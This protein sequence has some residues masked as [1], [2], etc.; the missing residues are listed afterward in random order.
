[1][2]K[3]FGTLSKADEELESKGLTRL[4]G[5][6]TISEQCEI[7]EEYHKVMRTCIIPEFVGKLIMLGLKA[8]KEK[9][10]GRKI[11]VKA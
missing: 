7:F 2:K 1:M 10:Q 4:T 3:V 6:M 5:F 8:Y 9:K 11:R